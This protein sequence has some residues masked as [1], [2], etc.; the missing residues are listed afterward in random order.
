M[1]YLAKLK[2]RDAAR[3]L[4]HQV[5]RVEETEV[6]ESCTLLVAMSRGLLRRGTS[7]RREQLGGVGHPVCPSE[8][9]MQLLCILLS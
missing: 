5:R 4:V 6:L 9:Q 2:L 1:I 3:F 7:Y 8:L